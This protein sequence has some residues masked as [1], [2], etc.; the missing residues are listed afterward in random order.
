M[1]GLVPSADSFLRFLFVLV[2]FNSASALFCMCIAAAVSNLGTANLI[3]SIFM[4]FSMLFR[5]FLINLSQIP[6]ALAWIQYLSI[7]RYATEALAVNEA[8]S[9]QIQD[10]FDGIPINIPASTILQQLFG[11]NVDGYWGDAFALVGWV[12]GF[13]AVFAALVQWMMVERR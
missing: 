4:L 12:V 11:F 2:L 13:T 10:D 8:S 1:I 7:F 6:K 9:S 5:G 3:S